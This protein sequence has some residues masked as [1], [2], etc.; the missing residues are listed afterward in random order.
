MNDIIKSDLIALAAAIRAHHEAAT[1]AAAAALEHAREA[2]LLLAEAKSA[3]PH[4]Q[5]LPWLTENFEMSERTA[6]G[7]MRLA[8]LDPAKWQRVADLPLRR[9]LK[10][11]SQPKPAEISAPTS[12][13]ILSQ[14]IEDIRGLAQWPDI[15]AALVWLLFADGKTN[16]EIERTTGF[17]HYEIDLI[18]SPRPPVRF[19]TWNEMDE[20]DATDPIAFVATYRGY[21]DSLVAAVTADSIDSAMRYAERE[22]MSHTVPALN[23]LARMWRSRETVDMGA[24]RASGCDFVK[25]I[26]RAFNDARVAIGLDRDRAEVDMDTT[27]IIFNA[28]VLEE[29]RKL[30][31]LQ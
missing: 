27:D 5:W 29:D 1:S 9:A 20:I 14:P 25:W 22:D 23:V 15:E 10:E 2:G 12:R 6:R 28:I 16:D 13:P 31:V 17:D 18:L 3:V 7:Y 21:V 26:A 8:R 11:L 24:I 19:T 4:G 30:R